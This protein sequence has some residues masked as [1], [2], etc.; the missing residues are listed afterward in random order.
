M[1][2]LLCLQIQKAYI[3]EIL[4]Q[5]D[6]YG[7]QHD[8]TTTTPNGTKRQKNIFI[9]FFVKTSIYNHPYVPSFVYGF[10]AFVNGVVVA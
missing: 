3:L 8:T 9:I 2:A 7:L 1:A 5:T 4:P 6:Q 10:V